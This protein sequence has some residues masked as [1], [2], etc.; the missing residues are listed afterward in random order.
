MKLISL[1][2]WKE[3]LHLRNDKLSIRLMIFPVILQVLIMGY[4]LTTEVKYT[5]ITILD[6]CNSVS[7]RSLTESIRNNELF[8]YTGNS[9]SN[10]QMREQIDNGKAK[11]G[12]IIPK[13]FESDLKTAG[14]AQ[15]QLLIDGQDANSSNV[16]GGYM[17]AII[18]QWGSGY[19]K[20]E[21]VK[22]GIDINTVIPITVNPVILFN[23]SLK[24]TWYMVP[25]LVVL[26]ITMVTSLLTGLSIVKEKE[27]GTLEQMMVTP[28]EP[29][30]I[31]F[32]KTIPYLLIGFAEL[33]VF[34]I[35]TILWFGIPFRG[36]IFLLM[37]FAVLYMVS[38]L[39]IGILTSTIAR[40]PQQVLFLIWFLLI[41]FILLSGFFIPVENMPLWVQNM[42]MIN[43]VKYFMFAIREIC[44]KGTGIRD[45][46][47]EIYGMSVIGTVVFSSAVMFF[48]RKAK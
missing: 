22:K 42:T 43:P 24:S 3:F 8:R 2:I 29:I 41:F 31:I 1:M 15:V 9:E 13:H 36:N 35:F 10:S 34:I 4:A 30:H 46:T 12:L 25:A 33:I 27:K 21:A 7:S 6:Q 38:S 16:A 37:L 26:L 47:K 18:A 11:L 48:H 40:T 20:N 19:L 45:L 39:G 32:G 23:P 44:L 5:P 17:N 14:S 28:V